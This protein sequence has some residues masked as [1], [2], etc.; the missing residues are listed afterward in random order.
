MAKFHIKP[1]TMEIIGGVKLGMEV[2]FIAENGEETEFQYH[3][4]ET[5]DKELVEKEL[6]A[7]AD[8]FEAQLAVPEAQIP[9]IET[10]KAITIK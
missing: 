3:E 9:D 5:T 1:D 7:S 8:M 6:Q 4:V 2:K 10:G